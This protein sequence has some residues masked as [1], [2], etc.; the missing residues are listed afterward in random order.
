MFVRPKSLDE[1][2]D[3][4]PEYTILHAPRLHAE[5]R[6][7]GTNSETFVVINFGKKIVLVGG[8]DYSGEITKSMFSIMNYLLPLQGVLPMHCSANVGKDEDCALFFG[9]SGTGKTSLSANPE[10]KLIGDDEHGWGDDGIFNF[11]EFREI[12]QRRGGS[13]KC[14]P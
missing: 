8:S 2:A 11:E 10:R 3:H 5:S 9:L 4:Q 1:V 6:L 7:D 14:R 13:E 12:P